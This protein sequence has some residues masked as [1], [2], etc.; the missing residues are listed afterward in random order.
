MF[1]VTSKRKLRLFAVGQHPQLWIEDDMVVPPNQLN[2]GEN[3]SCS[4]KIAVLSISI[5]KKWDGTQLLSAPVFGKP[6][7]FQRITKPK[8]QNKSTQ[9][10]LDKVSN[11]KFLK[12]LTLLANKNIPRTSHPRRFCS[13]AASP[14]CAAS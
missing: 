1:Y 4:L 13:S 10:L 9:Q 11:I 6:E 2:P 14:R 7:S 5:F 12:H 3:G 8:N